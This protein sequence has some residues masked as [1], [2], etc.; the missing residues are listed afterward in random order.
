MD[1]AHQTHDSNANVM[2]ED[3]ARRRAESVLQ[4][5][6]ISREQ[7]SPKLDK[8]EFPLFLYIICCLADFLKAIVC[9]RDGLTACRAYERIFGETSVLV[10]NVHLSFNPLQKDRFPQ[11]ESF[12]LFFTPAMTTLLELLWEAEVEDGY[13]WII[14]YGPIG[15]GKSFALTS[16]VFVRRLDP[17]KRVVYIN[18][19]NLI[20]KS[21][22]LLFFELVY[23][24]SHHNSSPSDIVDG[25]AQNSNDSSPDLIALKMIYDAFVASMRNRVRNIVSVLEELLDSLSN[26]CLEEEID[27]ELLLDQYNVLFPESPASSKN[28]EF[29]RFM[30]DRFR[31]SFGKVI[32]VS[33]ATNSDLGGTQQ[34]TCTVRQLFILPNDESIKLFCSQRFQEVDDSGVQKI[35]SFTGRNFLEIRRLME[36][37]GDTIE[38]KCQSYVVSMGPRIAEIE[39]K[40]KKWLDGY[41][42]KFSKSAELNMELLAYA[43][44]GIEIPSSLCLDEELVEHIDNRYFYYNKENRL[45]YS[46]FPAVR[47]TSFIALAG[48]RALLPARL[49]AMLT[50]G[51]HDPSFCGGL[52]ED[53]LQSIFWIH[54]RHPEIWL[55]RLPAPMGSIRVHPDT[56]FVHLGG[57]KASLEL[58]AEKKKSENYWFPFLPCFHNFPVCDTILFNPHMKS[59]ILLQAA[60][61]PSK[62]KDSEDQFFNAAPATDGRPDERK[63]PVVSRFLIF[64][65]IFSNN[66]TT[67]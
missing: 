59:F 17:K 63:G 39:I 23:A 12:L 47:S 29:F 56:T 20:L 48:R 32:A 51:V 42:E 8:G 3:D 26:H 2:S 55:L 24:F 16:I 50:S 49:Y 67:L 33:S 45:L 25:K 36:S 30:K 61:N 4:K 1:L 41:E 65:L 54:R 35:V 5:M 66:F 40:H 31:T 11:L 10:K 6:R 44:T 9:G 37:K 14:V 15:I 46:A 19:P 21:P 13:E 43:D 34:D 58:L 28:T 18:N 22:A 64:I 62:H 52:L 57:L 53:I 7:K 27:F 38:E 60:V